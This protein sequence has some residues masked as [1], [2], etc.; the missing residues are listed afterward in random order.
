MNRLP[1]RT[2]G[3]LTGLLLVAFLAAM[4]LPGA[5]FASPDDT[6]EPLL[7]VEIVDLSPTVLTRDSDLRLTVAATNTTDTPIA[8]ATITLLTQEWTPATRSAL[9][10]WLSPDRY[11][12]TRGLETTTLTAVAPGERREFEITVPATAFRFDTWGPRGIEVRAQ[13]PEE[14]LPTDRERTWVLWWDE[15]RVSP[16]QFG[17]LA[18]VTP[19]V[20]ELAGWS[21]DHDRIPRMLQLAA[22]PG[23]TVALDPA[24]LALADG[25]PEVDAL[26]DAAAAAAAALLLPWGNADAAALLHAGRPDLYR[27][28]LDRG[29]DTLAAA[30]ARAAGTIDWPAT[31]DR[32]TLGGTTGD[33]VVL[34]DSL[35]PELTRL[36]STRDARAAVA[37]RAA[38]LLDS[39]LGA[40]LA[41]TAG[42]QVLTPVQQRQFVAATLAVITRE[43]PSDSRLVVAALPFDDDG[44]AGVLLADALSLPWVRPTAPA[45]T[46]PFEGAPVSA[47]GIPVEAE[48]P[49][50]ALTPDLL[51][52]L[53][54]ARAE[55]AVAGE[56]TAEPFVDPLVT[57]LALQP[58]AT[59]RDSPEMR[60]AQLEHVVASA[61]MVTQ[62]VTVADSS[63]ILM[64]SEQSNFPVRLTS[65]APVDVTVR[66]ELVP[67]DRRM[68]GEPTVVTVPAGG[69]VAAQVP[70]TAV[71]W[72]DLTVTVRLSTTEGSPLGS[73]AEVPVRIR[74]DWENIAM[75]ALAAGG[76]AAFV[77]GI[78]RTVRRNR[79]TDRAARIE[80]A[81]EELDVLTH[82]RD[83]ASS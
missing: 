51:A 20:T 67:S 68:Q 24:V 54:R 2:R 27:E 17:V 73:P 40:A 80:A 35:F 5:T 12:A 81:A 77:F 71:G 43:R 44:G 9:Q 1:R 15:P 66:V 79:A 25:Q 78:W 59:W 57:Q 45:T 18:P 30:G 75:T 62:G 47:D 37:G 21:T 6:D 72:G 53:D 3:R 52:D 8:E 10:G 65:T 55:L 69:E 31:V 28:L 39:S 22:I 32:T 83:G 64:I 14:R 36:T 63:P 7:D 50:G 33:V 70:V 29:Q 26:A 49:E 13:V 23:V 48:L 56:A 41:G 60:A 11:R 34:S 4:T 74:A 42:D 46:L 82:A 38:L 61:R 76:G 58:S 16:T 19:T